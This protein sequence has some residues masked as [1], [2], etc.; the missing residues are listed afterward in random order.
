MSPLDELKQGLLELRAKSNP[1]VQ[2]SIDETL[3]SIDAAN[4]SR[5][6]E[7]LQHQAEARANRLV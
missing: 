1:A 5:I 7:L 4:K 6:Q 3:K 2:A